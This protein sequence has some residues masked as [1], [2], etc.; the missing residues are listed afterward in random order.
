MKLSKLVSL[1]AASLVSIAPAFA[2]FNQGNAVTLGGDPVFHLASADGMSGQHRAWVTQDRLDNA[3][4]LSADKS[5]SAVS[6]ERVNG[7]LTLLVG[8]RCVATADSHTAQMA[9]VSPRQLAD[10][11]ASSVKNFLSSDRAPAYIASL[12]RPN[13]LSADVAMVERRLYAPA[14][15]VLPVTLKTEISSSTAKVGDRVEGVI[16]KDVRMGNYAIPSGSLVIGELI[17]CPEG[18]KV[19]LNTLRLA[20][21]TEIPISAS[22]VET[23]AVAVNAPHPVCTIGMPAVEQIGTRMPATIAIG[24]GAVSSQRTIVLHQGESRV[25]ALGQPVNVVLDQVTPVAVITTSHSM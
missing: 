21:G 1:T 20:S 16:S 10:N 24:T 17:Q 13:Q 22:M 9:G 23:Y 14:G 8:G 11:M 5:P 15:T 2:G 19:E 18:L 6:V 25:I 12:K 4:Y 3:L 7:A